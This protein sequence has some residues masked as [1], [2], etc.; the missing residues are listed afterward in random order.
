MTTVLGIDPSLRNTGLA[1]VR[2]GQPLRLHSIGWAG[3]DGDSYG[4]RRKRIV[5]L[6]KAVGQWI[7]AHVPLTTDLAVIEGPILHGKM[8]PSY[9]DRAGLWW[10]LYAALA[11]RKLPVAVV[12][13]TTRALWATGHGRAEKEAVLSTV[14]GWF[15]ATKVLNHD[16]A[17]AITLAMLGSLKLGSSMPFEVKQRHLNG[18]EATTWPAF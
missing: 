6:T 17:D 7:D 1:L 15:P 5:S 2:D 9:F 13:P 18:L 8:L 11:Q 10:G 12:M 4:D 16:I 3:H 14:R